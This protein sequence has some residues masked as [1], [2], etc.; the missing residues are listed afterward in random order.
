MCSSP[1]NLTLYAFLQS[2]QLDSIDL[3][4]LGDQFDSLN[5]SLS[6]VDSYRNTLDNAKQSMQVN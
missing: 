4:S 2:L 1:R 5:A 3:A 6:D